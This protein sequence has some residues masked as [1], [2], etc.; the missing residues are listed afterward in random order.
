MFLGYCFKIKNNKTIIKLRSKTFYKVKKRIKEVN[1]LYK[2]NK[3]NFPKYFS[4]INN[5]RFT[6]KYSNNS[7]ILKYIER[8]Y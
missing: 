6:F 4:S 7:K 3:I 8:N 5:Y 2:E 1:Y